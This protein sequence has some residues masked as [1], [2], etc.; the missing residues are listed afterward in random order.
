[1]GCRRFSSRLLASELVKTRRRRVAR[2]RLPVGQKQVVAECLNDLGKGGA[3]YAGEFVSDDVGIDNGDAEGGEKIGNRGFSATDS[4]G[5][6][7]DKTH[8][9]EVACGAHS[10]GLLCGSA[11]AMV[12][13]SVSDWA[14]G[15]RISSEADV[16]LLLRSV[17]LADRTPWLRSV[18][19]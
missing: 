3:M 19:R 1:M 13:R 14:S 16:G 6:A 15:P 4:A 17:T 11:W 5:Q 10:V 8:G 18:S 2:S 7:N 9:V 12:W